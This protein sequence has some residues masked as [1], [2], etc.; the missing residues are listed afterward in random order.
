MFHGALT[1]EI[2]QGFNSQ[3][4][5]TA[6]VRDVETGAWAVDKAVDRSTWHAPRPTIYCNR[7]TL[8][9]VMGAGWRGD[10]WLAWPGYNSSEPPVFPGVNV[11]AVQD[12]F[13]PNYDRSTVYDDTWPYPKQEVAEM[14]FIDV[15]HNDSRHPSFPAGSFKAAH[16]Y[17]D[18]SDSK[19]ILVVRLAARSASK[20]YQIVRASLASPNPMVF[21]FEEHDVDALSIVNEDAIRNV[22]VTLV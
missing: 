22:G 20:G 16:I 12:V 6:M 11:V 17:R 5:T 4:I 7:N 8:P 3:P 19:H 2:D 18:F 15:P 10:V 1:V 14:L 13:G 21:T 9:L